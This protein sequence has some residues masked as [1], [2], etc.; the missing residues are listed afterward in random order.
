MEGVS[1]TVTASIPDFPAFEGASSTG[2]ISLVDPCD[3]PFYLAVHDAMIESTTYG[4]TEEITFPMTVVMPEEC[5]QE[6]VFSCKYDGGPY[7]GELDPCSMSQFG[8]ENVFDPETGTFFFDTTDPTLFPQGVY[9]FTNTVTIGDLTYEVPFQLKID[10]PCPTTP[11]TIEKNPFAESAPYLYVLRD[12][13]IEIPFDASELGSKMTEAYCGAPTV[14]FLLDD[15]TPVNDAF[16]YTTEDAHMLS[17]GYTE[18]FAT[19]GEFNMKF[20]FYFSNAPDNY[21]DSDTWFVEVIDACNPPASYGMPPTI[22]LPALDDLSYVIAQPPVIYKLPIIETEIPYCSERVQYR[23]ET[24]AVG[25]D[26]PAVSIGGELENE[27]WV[28]YPSFL[29]LADPVPEGTPYTITVVAELAGQETSKPMELTMFNPCIDPEFF[30][31]VAE[32]AVYDFSYVLF[33]DTKTWH[34]EVF[35]YEGTEDIK[36]VCGKQKDMTFVYTYEFPEAVDSY[37]T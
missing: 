23:I 34:H 25:T 21:V 3:A 6:A 22:T 31:V 7:T 20:R 5:K 11:L 14:E 10:D 15:G 26:G 27:I 24:D 18:D 1:Y 33:N 28:S 37:V 19:A 12:G 2:T 17:I 36:A 4:I 16:V 29:D 30:A 35:T 8:T 13:A 32:G 9:Y